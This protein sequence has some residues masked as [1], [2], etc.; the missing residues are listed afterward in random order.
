MHQILTPKSR[1]ARLRNSYRHPD[2]AIVLA[3]IPVVRERVPLRRQW[4]TQAIDARRVVRHGIDA[5]GDAAS[6]AVTAGVGAA[7][8]VRGAIRQRRP[9]RRM[10]MPR[11]RPAMLPVLITGVALGAVAMYYL[12][13]SYGRR[14]RALVKDKLAHL[15]HVVTHDVPRTVERK[16]RFFGGR[17]KGIGHHVMPSNGHEPV[18]NET[19]VARVRSAALRDDRFKAGEIHADAYEGCVTLRGQLDDEDDIR[20]L[21]DA[22]KHVEGV[23]EVRSYLHLP[24]TPPPNKAEVFERLPAH[25]GA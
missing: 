5:L 23:R 6:M 16:G 13:A 20:R 24:G 18:D 7:S 15:G 3:R 22:T 9:D 1:L 10:S 8:Q 19:L 11:V 21:V 14:R 17:A 2:Q 25:M 4:S 12:D